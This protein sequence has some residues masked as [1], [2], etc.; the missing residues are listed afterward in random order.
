MQDILET[1]IAEFRERP[2]PKPVPRD[3]ELPSLPGRAPAIIGMRR[4][5]KTWFMFQHIQDILKSGVSAE[6]ILYVNFADERLL[7]M[8]GKGFGRLVDTFF[9]LYPDNYERMCFLFF[10]EIQEVS[11]WSLV[12]RRLLERDN[13]KLYL[14]GSSAKLLSKEI[15]SELRGRS[16]PVEMWPFNIREYLRAKN[17]QLPQ[18]VLPP[19][20]RD[21]WIKDLKEYLLVGGF[22]E[23]IDMDGRYRI[24]ILQDYVNAV[25]FRDIVERYGVTNLALLKQLLRTLLQSSASTFSVNR[26]TNTARSQ[27]LKVSKNTVHE[28]LGYVADAFLVG[29]VPLFT[30]SLRKRNTNPKKIYSVDTGL[31][32]AHS[33][34]LRGDWGHLL[35]NLVYLDLRRRGYDIF[36][37]RSESGYEVDFALRT[38]E[39]ELRLIQ[40][41]AELD[42]EET[43]EREQRALREAESETGT[44]GKLV[45][46]ENY[47]TFVASEEAGR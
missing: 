6:Q 4:S 22:P 44:K 10:D 7:P 36:Y 43:L 39:G 30:E 25:L 2:L 11:G 9:R 17:D 31:A 42:S 20:K 15:A 28:Y 47:H 18:G 32:V 37:Y 14:T 34:G 27:G 12:V 16:L 41:C 8:D 35:E 13:L 24:R 40:V 45:T 3:I 38:P 19:S 33:F 29:T 46:L 23:V 1:I 21:R 5:G 26:F